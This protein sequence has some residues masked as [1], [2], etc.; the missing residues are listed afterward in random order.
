[1]MG[2]NGGIPRLPRFGGDNNDNSGSNAQPL[3]RAVV[4]GVAALL[5]GL[6]FL[7]SQAVAVGTASPFY[8]VGAARA[9]EPT[10]GRQMCINAAGIPAEE[11]AALGRDAIV[12]GDVQL[13]QAER[14]LL[15]RRQI[16]F[17]E[18]LRTEAL[19]C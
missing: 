18:T 5:A 3:P 2:G 16:F 8:R 9:S 1:M 17:R 13:S 6:V 14:R 15:G 10:T 12:Y 4:I 11:R 19:T 7:P